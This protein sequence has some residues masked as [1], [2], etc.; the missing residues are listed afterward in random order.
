MSCGRLWTQFS[1]AHFPL[2]CKRK[3]GIFWRI[4]PWTR[5]FFEGQSQSAPPAAK[6]LKNRH[7]GGFFFVYEVYEVYEVYAP[8]MRLY[9][10][11]YRSPSS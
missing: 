6:A 8:V 11:K 1:I 4:R 5:I 10:A 3:L 9:S 7:A 2:F